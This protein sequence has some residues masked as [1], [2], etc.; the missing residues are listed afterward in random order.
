MQ[1]NLHAAEEDFRDW[2][3]GE[4]RPGTVREVSEL[5]ITSAVV[6]LARTTKKT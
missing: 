3:C 6:L 1:H 4:D 5:V 2:R